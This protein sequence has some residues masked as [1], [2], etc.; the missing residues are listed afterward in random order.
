MGYFPLSSE[1]AHGTCADESSKESDIGEDEKLD[2]LEHG[3]YE[4][5][6]IID[7]RIRV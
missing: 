4:V 7:R 1:T 5:D 2:L 3:F 6:D